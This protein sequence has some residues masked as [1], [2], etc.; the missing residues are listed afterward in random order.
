MLLKLKKYW[1]SEVTVNTVWY[2]AL[3][4]AFFTEPLLWLI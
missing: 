3:L 4:V 2:Y 1:N